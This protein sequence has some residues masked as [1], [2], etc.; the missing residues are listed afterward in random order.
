M[1]TDVDYYTMEV[2]ERYRQL[3]PTQKATALGSLA[4]LD[5]F[6]FESDLPPIMVRGQDGGCV[7]IITLCQV[8]L[9]GMF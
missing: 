6:L 4:H 5:Y 7:T 3:Q 9:L 2:T 8:G 1:F